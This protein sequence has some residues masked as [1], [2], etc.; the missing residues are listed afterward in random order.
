MSRL[1]RLEFTPAAKRQLDAIPHTAFHRI[2]A[3]LLSLAGNPR[4]HGVEMLAGHER[5]LRLRVG[6]YRVVYRVDDEEF[7]VLVAK[8]GH[9]RDVY[10]RR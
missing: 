8:V 2:Q 4:P 3:R 7:V 9:R 10:R 5:F 1:Y 6:D